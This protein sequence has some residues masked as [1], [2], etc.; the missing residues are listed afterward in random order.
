ML[1]TGESAEASPATAAILSQ[2]EQINTLG[3]PFRFG[4]AIYAF[5][6]YGFGERGRAGAFHEGDFY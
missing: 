5:L 4:S 1:I 3:R 6:Q 2:R